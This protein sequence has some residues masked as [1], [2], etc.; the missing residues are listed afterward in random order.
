M[1]QAMLYVKRFI[2]KRLAF[3]EHF[4]A[5]LVGELSLEDIPLSLRDKMGNS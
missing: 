2:E 5:Q 1:D 4:V 3:L